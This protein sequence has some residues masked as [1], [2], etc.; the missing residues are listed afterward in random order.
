MIHLQIG[1]CNIDPAAELSDS[2]PQR[3]SVGEEHGVHIDLPG[4]GA[5]SFEMEI[6]RGN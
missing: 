5:Q 3:L 6:C 2:D 1:N 4:V